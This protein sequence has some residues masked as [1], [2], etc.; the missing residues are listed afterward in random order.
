MKFLKRLTVCGLCISITALFGCS[1]KPY[2]IMD[3]YSAYLSQLY[4][5]WIDD[6]FGETAPGDTGDGDF[7]NPEPDDEYQYIK[8][9]QYKGLQSLTEY[10][11]DFA[12]NYFGDHAFACRNN[13]YYL[14]DNS[15]G[16]E[17]IETKDENDDSISTDIV[18]VTIVF[19]KIII[20]KQNLYG[21][22]NLSGK[23]IV[24]CRYDNVEI[25]ENI[26]LGYYE[27]KTDIYVNDSL[28]HTINSKNVAFLDENFIRADGKVLKIADLSE[29]L[30]SGYRMADAP[31]DGMV[32]IVNERGDFGYS[33]YPETEVIIEPQYI[34]AGSF[35]NGISCVYNH[36]SDFINMI[37]YD[38]P[39]LIDKNNIA[40]F[41]FSAFK[42]RVLPDKIKV[43]GNYDNCNVFYLDSGAGSYGIVETKDTQNIDYYQIDFIPKDN[44]VYGRYVIADGINRLYSL[45]DKCFVDTVFK[46]LQPVRDKFIVQNYDDSYM[47][48]NENMEVVVDSCESIEFY[49]DLL[50]I[51]KNGK[52]AYYKIISTI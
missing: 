44:R 23:A 42:D 34:I 20:K 17:L 37:F 11:F 29:P 9:E 41:D 1:G 50:L 40:V 5:Y 46:S 10:K 43:F 21:V 2:A 51:K 45:D 13:E 7:V 8:A 30:I 38:Y 35:M 6:G 16:L 14:I 36:K 32:K 19:D 49:D 24:E 3:D 4:Q 52:Y 27:N 15:G 28:L 48:L 25:Y 18:L 31:S 33:F 12:L 26:V 22:L 39:L 47:L